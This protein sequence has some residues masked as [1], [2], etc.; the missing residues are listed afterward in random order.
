MLY[1]SSVRGAGRDQP[2]GAIQI[3]SMQLRTRFYRRIQRQTQP[4]N[5]PRL[6]GSRGHAARPPCPGRHMATAGPQ[7]GRHSWPRPTAKLRWAQMR[8]PIHGAVTPEP[9]PASQG[10][11]CPQMTHAEVRPTADRKPCVNLVQHLSWLTAR[12]LQGTR[13]ASVLHNHTDGTRT[14][15]AAAMQV[16]SAP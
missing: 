3:C 9:P 16:P 2:C 13:G 1:G 8:Q 15:G 10:P 14:P 5:G 7:A 6:S 11:T 4:R 12:A